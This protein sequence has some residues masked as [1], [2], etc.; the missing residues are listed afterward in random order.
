MAAL[1]ALNLVSV[2]D[3]QMA[4]AMTS[5]KSPVL[6]RAN[7]YGSCN[8]YFMWFLRAYLRCVAIGDNLPLHDLVIPP[9][10]RFDHAYVFRRI[11]EGMGTIA[12]G[13]HPFVLRKVR[14]YT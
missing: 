4:L 11:H 13:S 10:Q 7:I 1:V 8:A 5:G 6:S 14:A 9:Q 3:T 12:A 2:K